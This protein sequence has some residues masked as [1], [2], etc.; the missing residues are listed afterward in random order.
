MKTL[1]L[2]ALVAL[3]CWPAL[4]AVETTTVNGTVYDPSATGATGGKIVCTLSA[5]GA[6]SNGSTMQKVA[7]KYQATI[8]SDGSVSFTLVPNDVI[9]PSGTYYTCEFTVNT[10]PRATWTE[11]WRV[12]TSPDPVAVGSIV[13]LDGSAG[14]S[15]AV[16]AG[17]SGQ[18]QYNSSGAFAGAPGMVL[19]GSGTIATTKFRYQDVDTNADGTIDMR[20]CGDYNGD[21]TLQTWEDIGACLHNFQGLSDDGLTGTAREYDKDGDGTL[22][23]IYATVRILPGFYSSTYRNGTVYHKLFVKSRHL[24]IQGSGKESTTLF[25]S[26]ECDGTTGLDNGDGVEDIY[27]L[28]NLQAS[29]FLMSD[30][31]LDTSSR[32]WECTK[33]AT[34]NINDAGAVN[35]C[36]HGAGGTWDPRDSAQ[37]MALGNDTATTTDFTFKNVRFDHVDRQTNAV[38]TQMHDHEWFDHCDFVHVGEHPLVLHGSHNRYTNNLFEEAIPWQGVSIVLGYQSS[39]MPDQYDNIISGNTFKSARGTV[40]GSE[41]ARAVGKIID[42]VH[43]TGNTIYCDSSYWC[44]LVDF[45]ADGDTTANSQIIRNVD[46]SD[47]TLYRN[48]SGHSGGLTSI[49]KM[50]ANTS[51][52]AASATYSNTISRNRIYQRGSTSNFAIVS[53]INATHTRI[54]GNVID[55]DSD[56]DGTLDNGIYISG[57]SDITV[58]S[59]EITHV[60]NNNVRGIYTIGLTRGYIRNNTIS[61]PVSTTNSLGI[62]LETTYD[63]VIEG[64]TIKDGS[65]GITLLSGAR[66]LISR[67]RIQDTYSSAIYVVS[68]AT[69]NSI[70][71]NRAQGVCKTSFSYTWNDE[72]TTNFWDDNVEQDSYSDVSYPAG[73]RSNIQN[74]FG[75]WVASDTDNDGTVDYD[76]TTYRVWNTK[77]SECWEGATANNIKTCL[78]AADPTTSSKTITLP[79]ATG[80]V[81]L[82]TGNATNGGAML[83]A[84]GT[85]TCTTVCT[86]AGLTCSIAYHLAGATAS[87]CGDATNES[88]LCGCI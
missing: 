28:V 63:S 42:G 14:I 85:T 8:Q 54:E 80:T 58:A 75:T 41:S 73:T 1:I 62:R 21:G 44:Q 70:V 83:W 5:S 66:D 17:S 64:N 61:V 69:V 48:S 67:N 37:T 3:V 15:V 50:Q 53:V 22:D 12:D 51:H 23:G 35:S 43:F 33:N 88:K 46:I 49:I 27:S 24:S 57:G 76:S 56:G 26:G 2:A 68:G 36:V 82:S 65:I 72:Q 84:T 47:N 71:G 38:A 77:S 60:T 16:A 59:N 19:T 40:L 32:R 25:W 10:I 11:L 78:A 79:N 29:Y 9:S 4:A 7:G 18:I 20:I 87:T 74:G 31:T 55:A 39:T 6:A 34:C 86:N 45:T 13:R 52:S 81:A 30:L